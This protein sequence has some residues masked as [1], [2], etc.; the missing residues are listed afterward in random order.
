MPAR[1]RVT[2]RRNPPRANSRPVPVIDV[3]S[4]D[5]DVQIVEPNSPA[6]IS[7]SSDDDDVRTVGPNAPA[8][9]STMYTI[10]SPPINPTHF[11]TQPWT[12]AGREAVH[13]W[14]TTSWAPRNVPAFVHGIIQIHAKE[15]D[16][17]GLALIHGLHHFANGGQG[18]VPQ[19]QDLDL[20]VYSISSIESF[21][22]E[23]S[24]HVIKV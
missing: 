23:A 24:N 18:P 14:H 7:V 5:N 20:L 21:L 10:I 8:P 1:A 12:G 4:D 22:L 2:N 6:P 11:P 16:G 15:V 13:R 3:S 9:D 19:P 17:L